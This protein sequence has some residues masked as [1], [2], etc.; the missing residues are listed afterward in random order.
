MKK[1]LV[2]QFYN[3]K[4]DVNVSVFHCPEKKED[5]IFVESITVISD[6]A[7]AKRYF[8]STRAAFAFLKSRGYILYRLILGGGVTWA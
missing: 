2:A 3:E 8:T 1:E 6:E 7:T 4:K 5:N